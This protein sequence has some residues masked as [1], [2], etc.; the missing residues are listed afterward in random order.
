[1][2]TKHLNDYSFK[3]ATPTS[4]PIV[5]TTFYIVYE[6]ATRIS[7]GMFMLHT[8]AVSL[9]MDANLQADL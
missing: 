7:R 2:C 5:L 3:D 4:T 6:I 1:M 8:V 9:T